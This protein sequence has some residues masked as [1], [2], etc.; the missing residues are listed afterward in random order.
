[1]AL[2]IG[3]NCSPV[4]HASPADQGVIRGVSSADAA[5]KAQFGPIV[6][7]AMRAPFILTA[8]LADQGQSIKATQTRSASSRAWCRACRDVVHSG[9]SGCQPDAGASVALVT[10]LMKTEYL[11]L[12]VVLCPRR[13]GSDGY[14]VIVLIYPGRFSRVGPLRSQDR[15][16]AAD[17]R[18][19][20]PGK[21]SAHAVREEIE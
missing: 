14:T 8:E 12:D 20:P 18:S 1:M 3:K 21:P 7:C 13:S 17:I 10:K 11:G 9:R 19:L 4:R 16:S 2:I 6:G 5:Q 15:S